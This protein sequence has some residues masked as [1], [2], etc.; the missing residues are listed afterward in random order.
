VFLKNGETVVYRLSV[1]GYWRS[2]II[3]P[4]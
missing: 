1:A 2:S 3:H 4:L